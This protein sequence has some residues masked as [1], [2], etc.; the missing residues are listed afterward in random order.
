MMLGRSRV[1]PWLVVATAVAATGCKKSDNATHG[2]QVA[3]A[4]T[5]NPTPTDPAA[6]AVTGKEKAAADLAANDPWA[7]K[8]VKKDPLPHPFLWSAEKDGKTTYFVGTVHMG[9]DAEVRMPDIVWKDFD[10]EP[11]FAMETDLS[12]I[13]QS[14]LDRTDGGTLQADLGAAYWQK[15]EAAVGAPTARSIDTKKPAVAASLME[16]KD[17]PQTPPMDEFFLARAQNTHKRLIYLEPAE[18]QLKLLDKWLDI[19]AL[20]ESLDELA[21]GEHHTKDL[22][23]A[24]IAG[25]EAKTQQLAD[26]D[27]ADWKKAGRSDAEYDQQMNEM[28][29]DRNASWIAELEQMHAAGGGFVAVGAMHLIGKRSVLDLLAKDGFKITRITP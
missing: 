15:L 27:R 12:G 20:K 8:A 17:M 1:L 10:T 11:A 9:I 19:R 25:D 18:K 24:Y 23:A 28:L 29:Y 5:T 6:P 26:E 2:G 14:Q 4:P 21:S 13:D 7:K 22:L 3:L 16:M